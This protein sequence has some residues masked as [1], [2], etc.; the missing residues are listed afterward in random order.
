M[1]TGLTNHCGF[2]AIV[3]RP[4]VGKSTF[5]NCVLGQ[6]ISITSRR[7]QTTRHRIHGI[8]TY[9]EQ[10]QIVYVDTPGLHLNAKRAMNHYMNQ[11]AK[12]SM[13]SV[14]VILF[15][16]EGTHWTDEDESVA[17]QLSKLSIPVVLVINKLDLVNNKAALLPHITQ[18]TQ[19]WAFDEVIPISAQ[20][21]KHVD[22]VENVLIKKMPES[23]LFFPHDQVTDRSERFLAAEIVREKLMRN[24]GDEVPYY[25]TVELEQ[26]V[27]ESTIINIAAVIW[28][29]K[30]GQKAIVIGKHGAMLKQ[31]GIQAR[32]DME[33][34]FAQQVYLQLWVKVKSG[35]SDNVR[36]LRSLGYAD[37]A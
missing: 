15:M 37:D 11:T 7:P 24:L 20:A 23:P 25:L 28:V 6:K 13:T 36:A 31:I 3:G 26:F 12:R 10:T 35:W 22:V 4:N 21:G 8:K 5:L 27:E 30:K 2:V 17:H 18:I 14:D 34:L 9:N 29:E 16:C 1:V 32:A 19:T 33:R